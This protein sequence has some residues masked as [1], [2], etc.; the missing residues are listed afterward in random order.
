[1]HF[2]KRLFNTLAVF[3]RVTKVNFQL[4]YGV[5]R[6]TKLPL[7]LVS[8]FGA[9]RLQQND[10]YAHD[11]H[12]LAQRFVESDI[13]VLTG[14]GPG[15]MQAASCGAVAKK[16]SGISLGIGVRGLGETTS[17]CLNEYMELDYFFARKYLLTHFSS[18]FVVFPGGFGTMDELSEVLT[19]IQTNKMP[20]L[21][22]VLYG[23]EYWAL[24]MQWVTDE[25]VIHGVVS[26]EHAALF[27]ITDDLEEAFTIV[28]DECKKRMQ[29]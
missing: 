27:S 6:L 16:G 26:K 14:G 17:P 2:F 1:M 12:K 13:S 9:A 22:I 20:K 3:Y 19:L 10:K 29:A 8:I 7:P 28:Q 23:S 15:I 5:W 24:F 21:P 25:A 18:G 11:A 4:A